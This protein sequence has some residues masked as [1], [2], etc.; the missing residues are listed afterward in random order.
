MSPAD[1]RNDAVPARVVDSASEQRRSTR[2]RPPAPEQTK[3]QKTNRNPAPGRNEARQG[4][5]SRNERAGSYRA[6]AWD[7]RGSG[8]DR[9]AAAALSQREPD[10]SFGAWLFRADARNEAAAGVAD[11]AVKQRPL[12]SSQKKGQGVNRTAT[13]RSN[14]RHDFA[15]HDE[16]SES[17]S[18]RGFGDDRRTNRGS[19][20]EGRD[21]RAWG[22]ERRNDRGFGDDRRAASGRA[23]AR[24]AGAS[25]RDGGSLLAR[26][27]G[28]FLAKGF[29]DWSR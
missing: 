17:W 28:S 26:D 15:W 24:D 13:R 25:A 16:R 12:P 10:D 11:S 14:V 2:E 4:Y 3:Q 18:D 8:D 5:A 7:D 27:G 29:W 20:D 1:A 23:A 22:D 9:R 19:R 6:E 21:D